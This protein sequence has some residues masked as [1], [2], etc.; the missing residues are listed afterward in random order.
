MIGSCQEPYYISAVWNNQQ[1]QPK[2]QHSVTLHIQQDDDT[3]R[4]VVQQ[5]VTSQVKKSQKKNKQRNKCVRTLIQRQE[6][7]GP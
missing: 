2:H 7:Q 4:A 1:H 5:P 6:S 3:S